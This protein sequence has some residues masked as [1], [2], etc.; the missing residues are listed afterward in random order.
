MGK[1]PKKF[2]HEV[3]TRRYGGNWITGDNILLTVL[4]R[5]RPLLRLAVLHIP[6]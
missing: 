6:Y 3:R 2:S 4:R 1:M 5:Y